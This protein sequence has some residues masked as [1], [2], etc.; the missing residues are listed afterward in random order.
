LV[1]EPEVRP[2]LEA[3]EPTAAASGSGSSRKQMPSA[4]ALV[5]KFNNRIILLKSCK[6]L[7]HLGRN[8]A[9]TVH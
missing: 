8:A 5:L 6:T 2:V 4:K 9:T 7:T 3:S 1:V